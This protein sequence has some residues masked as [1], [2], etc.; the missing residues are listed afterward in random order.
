MNSRVTWFTPDI[1]PIGAWVNRTYQEIQERS[2]QLLPT[3]L[4]PLQ[5]QNLWDVCIGDHQRRH[6]TPSLLNIAGAASQAQRANEILGDWGHGPPDCATRES[7]AGQDAMA[8]RRWQRSVFRHCKDKNWVL[9]SAV[10]SLLVE[11]LAGRAW[12]A[13]RQVIFAGFHSFSS[14]QTRLM[15][16]LNESGVAVSVQPLVLEP[17]TAHRFCFQHAKEEFEAVARWARSLVEQ[18]SC[19]IGVVVPDLSA[20]W[21]IVERSFHAVFDASSAYEVSLPPALRDIP[22]IRDALVLLRANRDPIPI[23]EFEQ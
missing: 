9:A 11:H 22:V 2:P 4:T 10:M 23:P 14:A 5:E 16:A 13:P 15:A 6:A 17:K 8:F 12:R 7:W 18:G 1:V 21:A 19:S 3:L 20:S